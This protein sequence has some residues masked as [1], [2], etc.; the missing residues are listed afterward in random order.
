MDQQAFASLYRS[1]CRKRRWSTLDLCLYLLHCTGVYRPEQCPEETL[2]FWK[3]KK[4]CLK[5]DRSTFRGHKVVALEYN[6]NRYF[7]SVDPHY[8]FTCA[9]SPGWL[10]TGTSAVMGTPFLISKSLHRT[11]GNLS[12]FT[13][14]EQIWESL[15]QII[16]C[17]AKNTWSLGSSAGSRLFVLHPVAV[18]FSPC[19]M[20]GRGSDR[21]WPESQP[22]LV[23]DESTAAP[24]PKSVILILMMIGIILGMV[25]VCKLS[26]NLSAPGDSFSVLHCRASSSVFFHLQVCSKDSQFSSFREAIGSIWICSVVRCFIIFLENW[27]LM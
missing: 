19:G 4:W 23:S 11:S 7:E 1:I 3:R 2:L 18:I 21:S 25:S 13:F 5:K 16:N 9:C 26:R 15:S 27:Y 24:E 10:G 6:L 12:S 20:Q 22:F 8:G 17:S 14:F